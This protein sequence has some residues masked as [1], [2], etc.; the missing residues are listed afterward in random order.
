VG[1]DAWQDKRILKIDYYFSKN[2]GVTR[3]A[4]GLPLLKRE[5]AKLT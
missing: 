5:G 4:H 3:F 1:G 2:K